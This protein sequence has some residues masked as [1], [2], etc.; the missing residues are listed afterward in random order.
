MT[1]PTPEE[2]I[3][4]VLKI[5]ETLGF[6]GYDLAQD[7][8]KAYAA[9]L[10]QRAKAEPVE[11]SKPLTHSERVRLCGD[12]FIGFKERVAFYSGIDAAERA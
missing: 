1:T 12:E 9:L 11:Q 4:Y 5:A 7:E 3:A 8:L 6:D 10:E 2:H